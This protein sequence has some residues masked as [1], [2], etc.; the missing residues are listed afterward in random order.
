[1]PD[2]LVP[3]A[4]R[5]SPTRARPRRG[6]DSRAALL[7]HLDTWAP[8]IGVAAIWLATLAAALFSPDLVTGSQQEHFPLVGALG[9]LWAAVATGY[10]LMAGRAGDWDGAARSGAGGFVLS[11]TAVWATTAVAS[12]FAPS[13]VTGTD[14]TRIPLVAMLSRWPRWPSPASSACTPPPRGPP[15]RRRRSGE[16]IGRRRTPLG[17]G[18]S[19]A[20][21]GQGCRVYRDGGHV[22]TGGD[23]AR[24]W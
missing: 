6:A 9:W 17:H 19:R 20:P 15:F 18:S 12:I 5:R 1:M 21:T 7:G 10:V 16:S 14:P 23:L 2:F 22:A 3:H 13:L 8:G 11:V 4:Q 24:R